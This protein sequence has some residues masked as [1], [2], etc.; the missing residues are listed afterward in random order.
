MFA[1]IITIA[2]IAIVLAVSVIGTLYYLDNRVT[3]ADT[4][5]R[6]AAAEVSKQNY[7]ND[8]FMAFGGRTLRRDGGAVGFGQKY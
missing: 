3:K 8:N 5:L 2:A 1:T 7:Y 4:R 6:T